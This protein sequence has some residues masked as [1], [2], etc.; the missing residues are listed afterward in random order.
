ML[1]PPLQQTI[2]AWW[3]GFRRTAATPSPSRGLPWEVDT[4]SRLASSLGKQPR[5]K[6][7]GS[8]WQCWAPPPTT[9]FFFAGPP[10]LGVLEQPPAP[11]RLN[12]TEGRLPWCR[13]LDR[14][15]VGGLSCPGEGASFP[16]AWSGLPYPS[17]RGSRDASRTQDG[18]GRLRRA[19]AWARGRPGPRE[20][21]SA[22]ERGERRR[23][24]RAVYGQPS[25]STRCVPRYLMR[26]A[27]S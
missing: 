13:S 20:P 9:T 5:A 6:T 15:K 18:C 22:D 27:D 14:R 2:R 17:R 23:S 1:S 19:H 10:V 7:R 8:A 4:I 21:R 3:G 11:L 12:G 25:E 26:G 24:E 16:K